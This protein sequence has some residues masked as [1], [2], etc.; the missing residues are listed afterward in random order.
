M[1]LSF[2]TLFSMNLL[3]F[4]ALILVKFKYVPFLVNYIVL[5]LIYP[6]E[7]SG[8][9]VHICRKPNIS[10]VYI[11]NYLNFCAR[12]FSS[13]WNSRHFWWYSSDPML[14]ILFQCHYVIRV[15]QK[16]DFV[17]DERQRYIFCKIILKYNQI[18]TYLE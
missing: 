1:L 16:L 12:V 15:I 8:L 18:C 2:V 9:K 17:S 4:K 7:Y 11:L 10:K 5:V 13:I 3:N 6:K 14:L